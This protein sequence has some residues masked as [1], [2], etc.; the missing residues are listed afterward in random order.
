MYVRRERERDR[1]RSSQSRPPVPEST[2]PFAVQDI[3]KLFRV[4]HAGY[5]LAGQ[6]RLLLDPHVV[7]RHQGRLP[8]AMTLQ[9]RVILRQDELRLLW[10]GRLGY[11]E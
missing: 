9:M 7:S 4:L 5:E 6:V 8:P 10:R 1:D 11:G 3:S 2:N